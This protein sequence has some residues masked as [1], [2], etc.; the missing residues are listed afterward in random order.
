MKVIVVGGA[1]R[2]GGYVLRELLA[3]TDHRITVFDR[4]PPSVQGV[5]FMRGETADFGEVI[6]A[7]DGAEGVIH[8]AAIT[9][10]GHAPDHVLFRNNVMGTYHVHEAAY[11]VGIRRVVC[12]SSGAIQGWTYGQREFLPQYLPV[13]EDH[14][15]NPHDPYGLGKLCEEQIGRSYT[16]KCDLETVFL[17]PAF[18][19]FEKERVDLHKAGGLRPTRFNLCAYSDAR[20]LAVLFRLALDTPGLRHDVFCAVNDDSASAEPLCEL[21]PRVM[22][23]LGD[24]A[25]DLTGH[26]PGVSNARAKRVLGWQPRHSWRDPDAALRGSNSS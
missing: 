9:Q 4:V 21:L 15:N 10:P 1:G 7:L 19:L 22:P 3:N 26:K 2:I 24:L 11:R 20:D 12:A 17:R 14:P 6:G 16:F 18:A 13:D 23:A 8:L 25:K 5:G